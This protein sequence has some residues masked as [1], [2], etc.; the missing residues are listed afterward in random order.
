MKNQT[1]KTTKCIRT[2]NDFEF[3]Y[4]KFNEFYRDEGII[5]KHI[6]HYTPQQNR[7][8]ERMNMKG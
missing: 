5:R 2:K 3:Y 8:V 6:V 7:V 1:G 4:T